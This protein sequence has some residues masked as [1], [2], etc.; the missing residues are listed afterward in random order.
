MR[1]AAALGLLLAAA[2]PARAATTWEVDAGTLGV[3]VADARTPTVHLHVEWPVGRWSPWFREHHG[4][5][6]FEIQLHDPDGALRRR[7]DR[8]AADVTLEAGNRAVMLGVSCLTQDLE[9]ALGLVRD[10]LSNRDFDRGE[11]KLRAPSAR[12]VWEAS[13]KNPDIRIGR[14]EALALFRAG[15]P[16]RIPWEGPEHVSLDVEALGRMRDLVVRLPGRVVAFAGD[17]TLEQARA[18]AAG[19]LPAASASAPAGLAPDLRPLVE[20]SARPAESELRLPRLTQVYFAYGRDAL[21]WG[22]ADYPAFLLADHVLAGHFYSRLYVALR[23]EGGETYGAGSDNAGDVV[24]GPEQGLT[25][26]ELADAAGYLRGRQPFTR[27]SPEQRLGRW[28]YERRLGLPAG[29]LDA[30]PERAAGLS[31]EQ[32]NAFVARWYDP[33]HFTMIRLLPE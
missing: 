1:R 21:P 2:A 26:G 24:P 27:Q 8:L 13:L 33:A 23:H 14:A 30:L 20:P 25:A 17:L 29:F 32:V 28:L 18:A 31:L 5:E 15:D 10:M 4:A 3:L 6:A 11:L 7:A 16:R 12:I 9:P 22:E 19:L